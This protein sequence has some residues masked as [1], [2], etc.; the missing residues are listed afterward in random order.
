MTARDESIPTPLWLASAAVALLHV[1]W[2][3]FLL[4]PVALYA[5]DYGVP[6]AVVALVLAAL[7]TCGRELALSPAD[8]LVG[9][10]VFLAL[11]QAEKI[12]EVAL[13][14]LGPHP[15]FPAWAIFPPFGEP[16]WRVLD[17]TTGLALM[18]A[19]RLRGRLAIPMVVHYLFDLRSFS[20]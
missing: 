5:V 2:I 11:L 14:L 15:L 17:L 1:G 10:I 3:K 20:G 16:V 12:A 9:A 7:P 4:P 19:Y 8:I 18:G 13:E 6:A